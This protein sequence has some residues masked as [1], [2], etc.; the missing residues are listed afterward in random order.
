M[1]FVD[2]Y[3]VKYKSTP[4]HVTSEVATYISG[5]LRARE[6]RKKEDIK[7]DYAELIQLCWR[8]ADGLL[9][10]AAEAQK[11]G[12]HDLCANALERREGLFQTPV[13][14][15][16]EKKTKKEERRGEGA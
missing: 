7:K 4:P 6:V 11:A 1:S 12:L 8:I 3:G 15:C 10:V 13:R 9:A 2:R 5:R 16:R 14:E